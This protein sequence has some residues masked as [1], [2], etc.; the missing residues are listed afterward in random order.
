MTIGS[1][2]RLYSVNW[3]ALSALAIII[4]GL[5]KFSQIVPPWPDEDGLGASAFAVL[6]CVIGLTLGFYIEFASQRKQRLVGIILV[7]VAFPLILTYGWLHSSSIVVLP[8]LIQ[9]EQTLRRIVIGGEVRNSVDKSVAPEKLIERYGL[10]GTAWTR[11]SLSRSRVT[12]LGAY[13]SIFLSLTMGLG[14]LQRLRTRSDR[15][16]KQ[17]SPTA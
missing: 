6:C 2:L 8:Q 5:L 9:S 17:A 4:A 11:E 7:A 1:Y 3:G 14:M 13:M 12:L 16:K 10:D 15:P